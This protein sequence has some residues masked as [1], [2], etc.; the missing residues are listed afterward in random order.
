MKVSFRSTKI[1]ISEF[2]G[3]FLIVYFSCW[4]FALYNKKLIRMIDVAFINGFAISSLTWAS[5]AISNSHFNPALNLLKA[6]LQRMSIRSCIIQTIVQLSA[7]FVAGLMALLT[8][9]TNPENPS[10][11]V[12]NY[13]FPDVNYNNF[14][15]F[16]LE[17]LG[18]FFYTLVY[19]ATVM[20]KKGP[21]NVFGFAIGGVF[22]TCTI[23]FGTISGACLNPVRIFGPHLVSGNFEYMWMYILAN[24]FGSLFGGFYYDF[25]L[26]K[27]REDIAVLDRY[28]MDAE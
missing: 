4:S 14:Q 1:I 26:K 16:F 18:A 22:L 27:N 21:S 15:I 2:I 20:N 24:I 12:M 17:C 8:N 3:T 19:S 23:T 7:S 25:F 10:E 9:L 11:T 13:P 5:L 6:G 28:N